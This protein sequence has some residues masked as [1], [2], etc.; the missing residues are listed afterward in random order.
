MRSLLHLFDADAAGRPPSLGRR[1]SRRLIVGPE[2]A[3]SEVHALIA[4]AR[5]SIRILDHKLSD[6]DL[7]GAAARAAR[8][9]ASRCR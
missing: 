4:G 8:R 2:R 7:V 6:P 5:R 1:F 9:R 3:R